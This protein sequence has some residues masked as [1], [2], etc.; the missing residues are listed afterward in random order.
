MHILSRKYATPIIN[1]G[2]ESVWIDFTTRN[3][4]I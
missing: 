4:T 1:L 3:L 2:F